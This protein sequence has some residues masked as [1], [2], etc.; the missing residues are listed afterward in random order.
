MIEQPDVFVEGDK[1]AELDISGFSTE[2]GCAN[3]YSIHVTERGDYQITMEVSSDLS[4]IAQVN[5]TMYSGR[6]VKGSIAMTGN[7]GEHVLKELRMD[8]YVSQNPYVNFFFAQSGM[9]VHRITIK[10]IGMIGFRPLLNNKKDEEKED[11]Q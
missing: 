4:E 5:M 9:K 6:T 11:E 1:E 3:I 10:Y 8:A 2:A 7:G